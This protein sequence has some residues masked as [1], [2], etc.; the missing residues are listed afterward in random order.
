[1]QHV[2]SQA[3]YVT[4]IYLTLADCRYYVLFVYMI[5]KSVFSISETMFYNW[6]ITKHSIALTYSNHSSVDSSHWHCNC[7]EEFK[8]FNWPPIFANGASNTRAGD[9]P[10]GFVA[11]VWLGYDILS[12]DSTTWLYGCLAGDYPVSYVNVDLQVKCLWLLY[13]F[14]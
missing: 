11:P 5:L 7:D 10:H 1:M 8:Q 6:I 2:T 3:A 13:N 12:G 9:S 14:K 4:S